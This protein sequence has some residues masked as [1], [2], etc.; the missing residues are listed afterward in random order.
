MADALK[1]QTGRP[2]K[3]TIATTVL[4]LAIG[5]SAVQAGT[6]APIPVEP[7]IAA[8]APMAVTR[9]W[10]GGYAGFQFGAQQSRL[11]MSETADQTNTGA[12]RLRGLTGGLYAGYNW[13]GVN[14]LVFGVDGD[15]AAT[16]G[17]ASMTT[18]G[19]DAVSARMRASAALRARA[20]VAMGE[21]MFYGAVGVSHARFDVTVNGT[22]DTLARTGWTAGIGLEQAF[23]GNMTGRLEYR[24]SDYGRFTTGGFDG[25][26]RN[27]EIRAGVAFN[28]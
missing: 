9:N 25:R 13:Q 26:L 21:T 17:R 19:G 12:L 24:H 23:A 10:T 22:P 14:D 5:A 6:L 4:A 11:G 27:N 7:V 18:S 8:P 1:E 28:F 20:G 16:G 15:I 3:T 2:M